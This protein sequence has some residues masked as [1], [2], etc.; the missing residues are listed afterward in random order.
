MKALQNCHTRYHCCKY[1]FRDVNITRC[2]TL[3][4]MCFF[5]VI[6]YKSK[7]TML[8]AYHLDNAMQS[9]WWVFVCFMWH[10][11]PTKILKEFIFVRIVQRNLSLSW[12]CLKVVIEYYFFT[13]PF[14]TNFHFSFILLLFIK[15]LHQYIVKKAI[16]R[17]PSIR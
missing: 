3:A 13:P 4:L 16:I 9:Y 14:F 5:F 10:Y 8:T 11:E 17:K 6:C 1:P 15:R 12:C 7:I 2:C